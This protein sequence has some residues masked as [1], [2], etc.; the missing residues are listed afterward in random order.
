MG[1]DPC[2]QFEQMTL[3]V[4]KE[5]FNFDNHYTPISTGLCSETN[6]IHCVVANAVDF[7]LFSFFSEK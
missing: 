2:L 3:I 7:L 4:K 5:A 6:H 1:T